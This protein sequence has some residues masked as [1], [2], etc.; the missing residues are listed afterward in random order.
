M[1]GGI[2]GLTTAWLLKQAGKRVAVLEMH[3]LLTGQTGQTTAHLTE[4]LDTPYP[5]LRS[6]FGEKGARMAADV[7][8]RRHRADR[9]AGGGAAASTAASSACPAYRYAETERELRELEQEASAAPAGGPA[10]R[11]H[12]GGAAALPGEA[13][14]ARGG[15]GAVPPARVPAGARRARRGRRQPPL[16]GDAGGG[17]CRTARPAACVTDRRAPS[18]ATDVVEATT[19]PLNRVF[20]HTKL[21]RVPH[22]RGG[23]RR[24]RRRWRRALYYDSQEPYHYIRPQRVDG[25]DYAHR[26]RRGPQGGHRGGH[27]DALRRAGGVHAARASP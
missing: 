15:P 3:R 9:R 26:R 14:A 23:R 8:P 24:S 1:G 12:E 5:T 13:G 19:T 21:Y 4:L 10:V 27:A 16:R 20:L 25:V 7:Q 18:S 22:L 6:D 17:A 2:A 11:A